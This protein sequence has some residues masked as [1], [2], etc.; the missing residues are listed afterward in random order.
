MRLTVA[1]NIQ[2]NEWNIGKVLCTFKL[3][4]EARERERCNTLSESSCPRPFENK[5]H[6]KGKLPYSS[7]TLFS[8][9]ACLSVPY[10]SYCSKQ[11]RSASCPM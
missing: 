4:L 5:V 11:H 7:S 3:E 6:R 2:K 10:S 9:K 8:E 1:R